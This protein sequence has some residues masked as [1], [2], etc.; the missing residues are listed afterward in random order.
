MADTWLDGAS[1]VPM[2]WG[3]QGQQWPPGL[4]LSLP[5]RL[6]LSQAPLACLSAG[7]CS[8]SSQAVASF[9]PQTA[10]SVAWGSW[11]KR[12]QPGR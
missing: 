10:S 8:A 11:L 4:R 12:L 2:R 9:L 6:L 3:C 1:W 7:S 5:L